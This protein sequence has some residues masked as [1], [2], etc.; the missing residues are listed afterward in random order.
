MK[1]KCGR[2]R[3]KSGSGRM[4]KIHTHLNNEGMTLIELLVAILVLSIVAAAFYHGF[5]TAAKTNAKAK[6]QHKATSLA[7]NVMEGLKAENISDILFQFSYPV[8]TD[9]DGNQKE[10]FDILP[11]FLFSG[12]PQ[13]SVGAFGSY[14]DSPQAGETGEYIR[15]DDGKYALYLTNITM[16]N[17]LFDILV[18]LDG[19]P[20]RNDIQDGA[21][22]VQD[23]SRGQNYN[24]EQSV[25]IP[26]M[27][28]DYDAVIS[29]SQVYDRE[30]FEA[31]N[32]IP[33][34]NPDEVKRTITITVKDKPLLNGETISRVSALYEYFF[35]D[36]VQYSETDWV[37]DNT[38][39]PT[40][41]LRNIFLF[42]QPYYS[43]STYID[44]R[45]TICLNNPDDR[46]LELYVVKQQTETN[47]QELSRKERSYQNSVK[48]TNSGFYPDQSYVGIHTNLGYNLADGILMPANPQARYY[49]N[50]RLISGE[51]AL[52]D[53][54]H[55]GGLTNDRASDKILDVKI[56]VFK[57]GT[58]SFTTPDEFRSRA[59]AQAAVLDGSIRN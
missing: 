23:T 40:K 26:V 4:V 44:G 59:G 11:G 21:G 31:M 45:D 32:I 18:T 34:F 17:T 9:L 13:N 46:E 25:L 12:T 20:Y 35:M 55:L 29:N 24:S 54:L 19:A 58:G 42:Y 47:I 56:E 41:R 30:A 3:N 43:D 28:S 49:L 52:T 15:T 2:Q 39:E 33:G 27:D 8:Y 51:Q 48:I 38:D 36:T 22:N 6:L 50:G 16:E 14:V 57:A 53:V 7:Q 5:L 37:F 1:E 10:N